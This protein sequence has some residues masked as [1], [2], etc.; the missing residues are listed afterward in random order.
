MWKSTDH[1]NGCFPFLITGSSSY[2]FEMGIT[3]SVYPIVKD[4]FVLQI[5]LIAFFPDEGKILC[6]ELKIFAEVHK[7][8]A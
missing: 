2:L 3:I 7:S 5:N 1:Q 8:L 6:L 4:F